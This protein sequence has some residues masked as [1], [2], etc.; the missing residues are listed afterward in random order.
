[1]GIEI[2]YEKTWDKKPPN[3]KKKTEEENYELA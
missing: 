3:L 2:W 1:M